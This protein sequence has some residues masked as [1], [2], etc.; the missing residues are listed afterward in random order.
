[1]L[2]TRYLFILSYSL[3]SGSPVSQTQCRSQ[4][5]G[6]F[7]RG[8]SGHAQVVPRSCPGRAQLGHAQS[9]SVRAARSAG[10]YGY[11]SLSNPRP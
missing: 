8:N 6:K 1:M 7:R 5:T 11:H 4:E 10:G 2:V 9:R 3:V